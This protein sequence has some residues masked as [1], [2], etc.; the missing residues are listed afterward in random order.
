MKCGDEN[1]SRKL[2][3]FWSGHLEPEEQELVKSH[4]D[5]CPKCQIDLQLMELLHRGLSES[6]G[7]HL[8]PELLGQYSTRKGD[9]DAE[10]LLAVEEHL[11]DCEKCAY[12]LQF[13]VNLGVDLEQSV[14]ASISRL[15]LLADVLNWF[16]IIVRKPVFGY[17]LLLIT[18]YP[19]IMWVSE[20]HTDEDLFNI[21]SL[22]ADAFRLTEI[23]RFS[24]D[25]PTIIRD[26]ETSFIAFEI[27]FYHY[28]EEYRYDFHVSTMDETSSFDADVM[29]WYDRDESILFTVNVLG[30]P[31]GHLMIRADEIVRENQ[32][33]HTSR[34]FPFVL[35]TR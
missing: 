14:M 29:S 33:I 24:S 20:H 25:L 15:S 5:V 16:S 11:K 27:P 34:F 4:I 35:Q 32:T 19:A 31:D 18:L 21:V 26:K 6:I 8:S 3:D 10:T 22:R 13:L 12:D 1:I 23:T 7:E 30:L 28:L 2:S 17:I 9:L